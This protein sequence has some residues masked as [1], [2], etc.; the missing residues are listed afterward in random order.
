MVRQ[1]LWTFGLGVCLVLSATAVHATVVNFDDLQPWLNLTGS[2]YA[3]LTWGTSTDH[4]YPGQTSY[5]ATTSEDSFP[6]YSEPHSYPV[7]VYPGYGGDNLWFSFPSPVT[8]NGAWFA[9]V[10]TVQLNAAHRVRLRDDLGN[11]SDWLELSETPQYLSAS[12]LGTTTV[13][14]ERADGESEPGFDGAK[15]YTMDDITYNESS[16]VPEP[17][18]LSLLAACVA[19]GGVL[20]FRRRRK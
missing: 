17:S 14:V 1:V 20:K 8:F 18:S 15:W 5:W 12:F 3:G 19:A 10:P 6:T 16:A 13:F 4:A 11:T 2:G 9:S 7:Y